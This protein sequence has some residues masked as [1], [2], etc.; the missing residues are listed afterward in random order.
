[1]ATRRQPGFAVRRQPGVA[2]RP[3]AAHAPPAAPRRDAG[4]YASLCSP[5]SGRPYND[6]AS[7]G[8]PCR[9][10]GSAGERL[11]HTEEVTGSIPVSPTSPELA[12]SQL[13]S[14]IRQASP[15][16]SGRGLP[17]LIILF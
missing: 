8:A 7:W 13:S 12:L 1:M 4:G 14:S 3:P 17:L 2:A 9:A 16:S 6:P 15:L 11:V 5:A 10:I